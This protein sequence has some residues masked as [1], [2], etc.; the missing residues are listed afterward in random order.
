MQKPIV[1]SIYTL[2]HLSIYLGVPLDVLKNLAQNAP[3]GYRP[4]KQKKKDGGFRIIDNPSESLKEL[5]RRIKKR[6]LELHPLPPPI[7]GGV[8]GIGIKDYA[9]IHIGQPD[10]VCLDIKN[11]FPSVSNELVFRVYRENYGFSEQVASTL[12]KL[13]TFRGRLPQGAPSSNLLLN[14][15]ITPLCEE[16]SKVCET[17]NLRHSFWVDDI[18]ISGKNTRN[19]IQTIVPIVHKYGFSLK[20]RKTEVMPKISRQTTIGLVVNDKVS[21]SKIK[22]SKYIADLYQG[23]AVDQTTGRINH[24]HYIN[25]NQARRFMKF[26]KQRLSER[27][28][29]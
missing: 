18:T 22:Y 15:V 11:C 2:K 24:L 14:I 8:K 6:L 7:M 25:E 29:D 23:V 28:V 20:T 4:Y 17:N 3:K 9:T 12:T 21:I 5:Q 19:Y 27:V 26:A 1:E 10:V 16:I 13:T